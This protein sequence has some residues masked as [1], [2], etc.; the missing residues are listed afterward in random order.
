[1]NLA[2]EFVPDAWYVGA[3]SHEVGR[4]PLQRW[5]LGEPVVF[6]QD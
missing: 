4:Q 6:V 1:M 3:W 2:S 5:M